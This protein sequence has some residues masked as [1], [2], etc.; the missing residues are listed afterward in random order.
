MCA[1]ARF[2]F[3]IGYI[4]LA[5]DGG[6]RSAQRGEAG[7]S[8]S[9]ARNSSLPNCSVTLRN[10]VFIGGNAEEEGEKRGNSVIFG[11]IKSMST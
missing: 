3:L 1:G 2:A 8:A 5:A 10:R 7:R 4:N 11:A 9:G 6:E